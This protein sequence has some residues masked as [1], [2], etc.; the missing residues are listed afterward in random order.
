MDEQT[1]HAEWELGLEVEAFLGLK[2][3]EYLLACC[4]QDRNEALEKL[5]TVE[6]EDA[7]SIRAIQ[8]QIQVCQMIPAYLHEIVIRSRQA[9]EMLAK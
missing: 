1:L 9:E 7:K 4:E 3:G 2:V 8:Q 6:P 5:A